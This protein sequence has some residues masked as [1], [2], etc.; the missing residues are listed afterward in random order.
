MRALPNQMSERVTRVGSG[1]WQARPLK[2]NHQTFS[3]PISSSEG[4]QQQT[5]PVS[6]ATCCQRLFSMIIGMRKIEANR[7]RRAVAQMPRSENRMVSVWRPAEVSTERGANPRLT[8]TAAQKR[9]VP[10][11]IGP[12]MWTSNPNLASLPVISKLRLR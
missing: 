8:L 7:G 3:I 9:K 1:P 2:A 12:L 11:M 4:C 6:P 10:A 5:C